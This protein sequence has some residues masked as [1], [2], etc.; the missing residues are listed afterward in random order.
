MQVKRSEQKRN[1]GIDVS[2]F[3]PSSDMISCFLSL[4]LDGMGKIERCLASFSD[5]KQHDDLELSLIPPFPFVSVTDSLY[6]AE[7]FVM[8]I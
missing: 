3:K 1:L 7:F 4:L 6:Q 8:E 2:G 5:Y